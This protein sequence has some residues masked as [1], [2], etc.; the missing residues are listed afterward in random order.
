MVRSPRHHRKF[1][2]ISM[3]ETTGGTNYATK[4]PKFFKIFFSTPTHIRKKNYCMVIMSIK[5]Y[6]KIVKFMA[7]WSKVQALWK[8][9]Y[10][11]IVKMY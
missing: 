10:G 4:K 5:A 7:P 8:G 6:T 1:M 9:Q 11:Y 3:R 2:T